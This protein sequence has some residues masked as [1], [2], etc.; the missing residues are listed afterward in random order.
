MIKCQRRNN[1]KSFWPLAIRLADMNGLLVNSYRSYV[2]D[3]K[4]SPEPKCIRN[5]NYQTWPKRQKYSRKRQVSQLIRRIRVERAVS[6][7]NLHFENPVGVQRYINH[8]FVTIFSKDSNHNRRLNNQKRNHHL[9][10]YDKKLKKNN[11]QRL[12]DNGIVDHNLKNDNGT[13]EQDGVGREISYLSLNEN[14][15]DESKLGIIH[16]LKKLVNF[17][18]YLLDQFEST[19]KLCLFSVGNSANRLPEKNVYRIMQ[20]TAIPEVLLA[21]LIL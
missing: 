2:S 3:V 21:Q 9:Q 10:E 8:N 14:N 17:Y 12:G 19:L 16:I 7:V 6:E 13:D 1:Q 11:D 20:H 15:V 18:S 5:L 4:P